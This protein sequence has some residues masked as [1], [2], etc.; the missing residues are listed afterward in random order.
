METMP[1]DFA[2]GGMLCFLPLIAFWLACW[3]FWAW[4]LFDCL[5]NESSEGNDK[6]VCGAVIF[7]SSSIVVIP[8]LGAV[9]YFFIRR[10][11][12]IEELGR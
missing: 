4:M 2:L 3:V 1:V 8:M 7:F 6:I 11:R 5:V 9:A 12:R 10:P